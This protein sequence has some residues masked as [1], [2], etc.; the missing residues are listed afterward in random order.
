MPLPAQLFVP[1]MTGFLAGG[2]TQPR[3]KRGNME[4][5]QI[6]RWVF[7]LIPDHHRVTVAAQELVGDQRG[8][9]ARSE[10]ISKQGRVFGLHHSIFLSFLRYFVLYFVGCFSK[11]VERLAQVPAVTILS[12]HFLA[13][14]FSG[15]QRRKISIQLQVTEPIMSQEEGIQLVNCAHCGTTFEFESNKVWTSP[16]PIEK[17]RPDKPRRVVIPCPKCQRWINVE[18]KNGNSNKS[19]SK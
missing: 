15:E 17:T 7:N 5:E 12:G 1:E 10:F 18:L 13:A 19:A 16:G 6:P 8:F 14:T 3:G 9:W 11:H 4:S 2:M